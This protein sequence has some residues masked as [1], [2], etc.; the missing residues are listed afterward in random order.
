M[1]A[2]KRISPAPSA[3]RFNSSSAFPSPSRSLGAASV[4]L[5]GSLLAGWAVGYYQGVK[6]SLASNE[7]VLASSHSDSFESSVIPDGSVNALD[8]PVY[9]SSLSDPSLMMLQ[10]NFQQLSSQLTQ[11]FQLL[12]SQYLRRDEFKEFCDE[13]MKQATAVLRSIEELTMR[14][15]RLEDIIEQL[16]EN[17]ESSDEKREDQDQEEAESDGLS[18]RSF[19]H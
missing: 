17:H 16:K 7:P 15:E 12:A 3:N 4:F 9:Q 14:Y 10:I 18:R 19:H 2:P 1:S 13:H 6:R 5:G 8:T 11:Q